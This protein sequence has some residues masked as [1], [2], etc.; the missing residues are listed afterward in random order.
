MKELIGGNKA[1][2]VVLIQ[3]GD[4]TP[5]GNFSSP[6]QLTFLYE[7]GKFV[8]KL[9]EL[10]ISSNIFDMFG[11]SFIGVSRNKFFSL[12]PKRATIIDMLVT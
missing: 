10:N 5:K 12:S 2:F 1:I 8:G 9:P 4:Y 7:N 11:K 3:D 6:V